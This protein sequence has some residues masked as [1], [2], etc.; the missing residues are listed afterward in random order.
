MVTAVKTR[1]VH[2]GVRHLLP[3]SPNWHGDIPISQN[4][5]LVTWHTLPTFVMRKLSEWHVP[6]TAAEADAYLHVWQVTG[7]M[8]GIRDEYLPDSWAAAQAQS[9]Q[10]LGPVM[11]STPEGVALADLILTISSEGVTPDGSTKPLFN[12]LARY[13]VGDRVADM[14]AVRREPVWGP[15]I[16][17][18]FPAWVALREGLTPLP[19]V[20]RIA[21]T[22]D[23]V[24]RQYILFYLG[25][26][27]EISIEIPDT[28]R[29]G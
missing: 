9:E 7:H 22:I 16:R 17:G 23:E 6:V 12:A 26:G 5:M 14:S 10:I 15:L 29:P 2:A 28:N 21:W 25:E 11:T 8:L 3:R 24:I 13:L 4:D 18:G 19:L 27:R 20:P 1:L